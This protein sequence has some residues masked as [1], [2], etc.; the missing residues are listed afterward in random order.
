MRRLCSRSYLWG[1]KHAFFCLWVLWC[2]W[3]SL[4]WRYRRWQGWFGGSSSFWR[5]VLCEMFRC[6][7]FG[8]GHQGRAATSE[9][10]LVGTH[11]IGARLFG[12]PQN[13]A[14]AILITY[15][16]MVTMMEFW[17]FNSTMP[18]VKAELLVPSVRFFFHFHCLAFFRLYIGVQIVWVVACKSEGH[19]RYHDSF[20]TWT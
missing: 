6:R 9:C 18:L 11:K 20:W 3:C 15:P 10:S 7:L 12:F 2:L 5:Q 16:Y 8:C 19:C 1:S 13:K 14:L 4:W 17:K